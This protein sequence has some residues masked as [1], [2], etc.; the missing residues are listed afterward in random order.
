M[1]SVYG[2][3]GN[4]NAIKPKEELKKYA[5]RNENSSKTSDQSSF[6]ISHKEASFHLSSATV[7]TWV[8]FLG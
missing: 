4:I 3:L 5:L 6:Y 2:N 1:G 7:G 8:T